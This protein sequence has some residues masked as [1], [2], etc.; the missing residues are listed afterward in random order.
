LLGMDETTRLD[1]T[2]DIAIAASHE[3]SHSRSYSD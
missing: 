1:P 2:V 3:H